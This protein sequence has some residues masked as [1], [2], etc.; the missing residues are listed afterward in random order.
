MV[1][2][3]FDCQ[4]DIPH[5]YPKWRWGNPQGHFD[6][7]GSGSCM[8]SSAHPTSPAADICRVPGVPSLQDNFIAPKQRGHRICGKDLFILQVHHAMKSQS[9]CHTSHRVVVYTFYE[10]ILCKEVFQLILLFI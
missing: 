9:T 2:Q 3:V 7:K 10:P 5:S 8:D 6:C 1:I 4:Q